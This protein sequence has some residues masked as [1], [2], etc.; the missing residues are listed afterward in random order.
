MA[1]NAWP[2]IVASADMTSPFFV[3]NVLS[4][5]WRWMPPMREFGRRDVYSCS[6]SSAWLSSQRQVV[7]VFFKESSMGAG[8]DR[9]AGYPPGS[10]QAA[11]L[12]GR[13][14]AGVS[15]TPA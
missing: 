9:R 11:S 1:M 5:A 8:A 7:R 6:A 13:A 14:G 2:M 15:D 10:L 12:Q 3:P 4:A